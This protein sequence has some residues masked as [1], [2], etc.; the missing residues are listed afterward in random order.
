MNDNKDYVSTRFKFSK[1]DS[2][3]VSPN[4]QMN[5]INKNK[6]EPCI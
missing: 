2:F 6:N 1:K 3:S 4:K 5:Q